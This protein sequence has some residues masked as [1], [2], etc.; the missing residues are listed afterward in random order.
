MAA[1]ATSFLHSNTSSRN[2]YRS[3]HRFPLTPAYAPVLPKL[4]IPFLSADPTEPSL[5]WHWK[6][7]P[8]MIR[9]SPVRGNTGEK[10]QSA[11]HSEEKEPLVNAYGADDHMNKD[12]NNGFSAPRHADVDADTRMGGSNVN[13]V[14]ND[15]SNG[16]SAPGRADMDADTSMDGSNVNSIQKDDIQTTHNNG[17]QG[18]LGDTALKGSLIIGLLLIGAVGGFGAI[19][20][21]YR[22]QI[23]A[24]LLEFS[25]FIEG[26]GAAGY[27]LFVAVYAGLEVLAIPAIPLTMS[28]GLLFGTFTGTV[29]VSIS[30]T[31]A[32]TAAFLIARYVARDRILKLAEG[33]KKFLAIDKALGENGFRVV[34][35]LRLSPLLPFSLGNYLY[36]LT[37]VKLVPYVLG[38]WLGMLPGTWAYVSA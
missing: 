32:A 19:G 29:I 14:Q 37:S 33:N 6:L 9:A 5:L 34:A 3:L 21:I 4:G 7:G 36:G 26:Y 20:Y 15:D 31:I 28:A 23:N 12:D 38:S 27:A 25:D 1:M 13:S 35:L 11:E 22:E 2:C 18:T 24:F 16:F 30:G 17:G 10:D 8:P